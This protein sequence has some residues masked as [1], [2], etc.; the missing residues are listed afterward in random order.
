[1]RIGDWFDLPC[2]LSNR[3]VFLFF[4]LDYYLFFMLSPIA[5]FFSFEPCVY[6][7]VVC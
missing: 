6:P 3:E 2:S 1:M 7:V 5:R 4:A